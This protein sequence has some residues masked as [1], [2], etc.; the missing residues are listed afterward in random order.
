MNKDIDTGFNYCAVIPCFNSE[1]TLFGAID[2]IIRQ[3]LPPQEIIIVDDCSTDNSYETAIKCKEQ[4]SFVRIK[5]IKLHKNFGPAYARNL[6]IKHSRADLIA[7]LDADDEWHPRKMEIQLDLMNRLDLDIIGSLVYAIGDERLKKFSEIFFQDPD[8][9][10]IAI[11]NISA[12]NIIFS[13]KL[14]TPT[15]V[16]RK[17]NSIQFNENIRYSE[18]FDMW[19]KYFAVNRNSRV[20]IVLYPLVKLNKASFGAGGLSANIVKMEI[21]ELYVLFKNFSNSP[22]LTPFALF[23]SVLKFFRRLIIVFLR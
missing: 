17:N 18:D 22:F 3:T 4:F 13:N 5:I 10:K 12:G 11:K 1:K 15:V 8:M 21:G 20:C 19:L 16:I 23:Y 2:S 9:N 6:A 14:V 7:F